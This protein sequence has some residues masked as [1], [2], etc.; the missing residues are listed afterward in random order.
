[1]RMQPRRSAPL[2]LLVAAVALLASAGGAAATQPLD[3]PRPA[4]EVAQTQAEPTP[5]LRPRYEPV[6]PPEK[7]WYNS[8]YLFAATRG[9]ADST[10][11]PAVKAPLFLLT[12]PL[13]VVCLPFAALVGCFG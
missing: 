5:E 8:T 4:I 13:D 11:V 7:S 2:F 6:P 10:L 1:M 9:V 3:G 12:V